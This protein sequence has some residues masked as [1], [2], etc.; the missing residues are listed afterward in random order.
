MADPELADHPGESAAID[1]GLDRITQFI[2]LTGFGGLGLIA[3]LTFYDGGARYIGLPRINGF[4]DYAQVAYAIVIAS[5]FPAVLLRCNN[6]TI[7][8][9]GRWL[10]TRAGNWLETFG[11][12]ITLIFFS[13]IVWQFFRLT[14]DYQQAGR[15]TQTIEMPLAPWWWVT[16]SIIAL[17]VPVQAYIFGRNFWLSVTGRRVPVH[18]QMTSD[19]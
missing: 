11:S 4:S 16:T 7:R 14:L 6:I 2:A 18:E 9:L 1:A 19:A 5:C 15:T 10:G 12:V 13:L 8:F 3:L 17:C